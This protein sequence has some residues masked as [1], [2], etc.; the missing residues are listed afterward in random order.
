[1]H[2][3]ETEEVRDGWSESERRHKELLVYEAFSY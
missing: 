2:V 3:E 1:M